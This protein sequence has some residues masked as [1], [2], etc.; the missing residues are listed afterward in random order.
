MLTVYRYYCSCYLFLQIL[1]LK[2]AL[3]QRKTP[4]ELVNMPANM[5]ETVREGRKH[6]FIQ[7]FRNRSPFLKVART[8]VLFVIV[9][10]H[11]SHL[12]KSH[13]RPSSS[14]HIHSPALAVVVF[15]IF[16]SLSFAFLLLSCRA[17]PSS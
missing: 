11:K 4:Y 2:S 15:L 8:N 1:N 3:E 6:D 5:V 17:C 10:R 12:K 16:F 14:N 13:V 9:Y 7:K